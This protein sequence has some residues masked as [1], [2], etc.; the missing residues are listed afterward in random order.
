[1]KKKP[2]SLPPAKLTFSRNFSLARRVQNLSQEQIGEL[3]DLHRTYIGQVERGA[4][5]PTLDAAERIAH[6]VGME[7]WEI[8]DPSF[9]VDALIGRKA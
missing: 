2:P 9:S 5:I 7:L 8:L 4:A 6:A 3:A 1:M